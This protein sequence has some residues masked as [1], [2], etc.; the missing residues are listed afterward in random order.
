MTKFG[1]MSFFTCVFF[2]T[3][4]RKL[5]ID[6]I[7]RHEIIDSHSSWDTGVIKVFTIIYI[8]LSLFLVIKCTIVSSNAI[9]TISFFIVQQDF[10]SP[11]L[12]HLARKT[13]GK[14]FTTPPLKLSV[15]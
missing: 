10:I 1:F 15:T 6:T 4:A 12:T 14:S 9:N 13:T 7:T 3:Q 11:V 2:L 8:N 5:P